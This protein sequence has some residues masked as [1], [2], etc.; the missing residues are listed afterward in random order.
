MALKIDATVT[1]EVADIRM[2]TADKTVTMVVKKTM[3]GFGELTSVVVLRGQEFSRF[4]KVNSTL[5]ADLKAAG[6]DWLESSDEVP[7]GVR[8]QAKA[9]DTSVVDAIVKVEVDK[10]LADAAKAA[11]DAA[12]A[13]ETPAP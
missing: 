1:V 6:E 10:A 3:K 2:S 7:P 13:A 8:K 5:L 11:A 9:V 4:A 12:A